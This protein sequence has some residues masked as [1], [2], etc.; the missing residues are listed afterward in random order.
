MDQLQ[1]I[2]SFFM[3]AKKKPRPTLGN[4]VDL[5]LPQNRMMALLQSSPDMKPILFFTGKRLG[6]AYAR[7]IK[8]APLAAALLHYKRIIE[9]MGGA[10]V[11]VLGVDRDHAIVRQ[12]ECVS[13]YGAPKMGEICSFDAG[14]QTGMVDRITGKDYYSYETKCCAG[15]N[16]YCEFVIKPIERTEK[17][18]FALKEAKR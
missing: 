15:G 3:P 12:R 14:V 13:C 4:R 10:R 7:G 9:K 11:D 16:K 8:K 18:A 5:W 1:R 6:A 2:E 17:M